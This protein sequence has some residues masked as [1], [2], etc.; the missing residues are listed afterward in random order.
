MSGEDLLSLRV[1]E[2]LLAVAGAAYPEFAGPDD[3][4]S[5]SDVWRADDPASAEIGGFFLKLL[6]E[7]VVFERKLAESGHVDAPLVGKG[8]AVVSD[9]NMHVSC[10]ECA[11]VD[12][13][14]G[15]IIRI[16]PSGPLVDGLIGAGVERSLGDQ[17]RVFAYLVRVGCQL[18]G[19]FCD[20]DGFLSG[21][22]CRLRQLVRLARLEEGRASGGATDGGDYEADDIGAIHG[23]DSNRKGDA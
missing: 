11:V 1:A 5:E 16:Q 18:V 13:N 4:D 21:S 22:V 23:T 14:D 3:M 6:H 20:A 12:D 2:A 7:E 9:D 15:G 17:I 19:L 8:L 10:L